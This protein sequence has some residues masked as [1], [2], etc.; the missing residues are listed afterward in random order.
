[1]TRRDPPE[2]GLGD[3]R[4]AAHELQALATATLVLAEA[5]TG[6][7]AHG[8]R[9]GDAEGDEFVRSAERLDRETLAFLARLGTEPP[10]SIT[11]ETVELLRRVRTTVD[12]TRRTIV[13][14]ISIRRASGGADPDPAQWQMS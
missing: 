3:V 8:E 2:D 7:L 1:M 11:H 10:E 5:L 6:R 9:T 12:A 13:L 4:D 14:M